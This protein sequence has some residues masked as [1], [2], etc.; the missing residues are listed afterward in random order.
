MTVLYN[1]TDFFFNLREKKRASVCVCVNVLRV[2][3][4]EI[5]E[6]VF[7]YSF[8]FPKMKRMGGK[9]NSEGESAKQGAW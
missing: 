7:K 4:L 2:N 6:K 5:L 1:I 9:N 3:N 8:H